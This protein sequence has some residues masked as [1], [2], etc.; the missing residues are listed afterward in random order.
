MNLNMIIVLFCSMKL[1]NS[2]CCDIFK[3]IIIDALS[4]SAILS[5]NYLAVL[6]L[7]KTGMHIKEIGIVS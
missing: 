4:N 5:T 7:L 3:I 2:S 1:N 6:V